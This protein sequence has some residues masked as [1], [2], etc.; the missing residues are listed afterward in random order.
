MEENTNIVL[1]RVFTRN[2]LKEFVE[3]EYGISYSSAIKKYVREPECKKNKELITEIYHE[4]RSNYRNEYFYKNTLINK[5]LLGIHNPNTTVALTEIPIGK[6]KADFILI[7]GKAIVYEIKSDLDNL[8]RLA[9]Q[10]DDYYKAFTRVCIVS[11]KA[12]CVQ[13]IERFSRTSVGIYILTERNCISCIKKPIEDSS[14]LIH[15]EIFKILRKNE[16]ENILLDS[17]GYLP[18]VSPYEYY[19]YCMQMFCQI[20]LLYAY[21]F[22]VKELKNRNRIELDLYSS[23]PYELKFLAYFSSLKNSDY[24]KLHDFLETDYGG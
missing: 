14:K 11:C 4:I 15:E 13:L 10:I 1:C 24:G 2:T 9:N 7:N 23:I 22:F 5:L 19:T 8:D 17:Y 18:N 20:D 21:K 16:Y 6:S 3:G 12:N